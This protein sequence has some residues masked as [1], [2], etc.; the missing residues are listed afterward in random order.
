MSY[1]TNVPTDGLRW[2]V[3][4]IAKELNRPR[5][6][7]YRA[8][9][10]VEAGE[11][12]CFST[13]QVTETI[14]GDFVAEKTRLSRHQANVAE[15]EDRKMKSELIERNALYEALAPLFT[16]IAQIVRSSDL[17]EKDKKEILSNTAEYPLLAGEAERKS[18][19]A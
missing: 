1:K 18:A 7:I 16:A 9:K 15:M 17:S 13:L 14:F 11:D 5:T 8:F 12:G 3:D 6:T 10:K 4:A 19:Q 2:S